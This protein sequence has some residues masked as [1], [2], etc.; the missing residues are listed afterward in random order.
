MDPRCDKTTVLTAS[1]TGPQVHD[2]EIN[3][4]GS[5][6]I[7]SP[8]G[9]DMDSDTS[10]PGPL[11]EPALK[12]GAAF[13]ATPITLPQVSLKEDSSLNTLD[14]KET[15]SSDMTLTQD[16][17]DTSGKLKQEIIKIPYVIYNLDAHNH[18]YIS[19]GTNIAYTDNEEPEMEYFKIA[20][21]FEEVQEAIQYRNH[22]PNHPKLPVPPQSDLISSPAKVKLHRRVELKDH[23]A[24]EE[25]KKCFEELCQQFP[26]V[27]STNNEDIGRTNLIT[28]DIDTGDS[29]P[30][31]KKLYTLPL[32]HYECIQ[33]EIE[34][35]ERAGIITRDVSPWA[36][37]V[38]IVPKKSALGKA[39]RRRMC[40]DFCA[41]NALQPTVIKAD[42]KAKGNFTLH[43]LPNIDHLYAQLKGAKIFTTLDLRS[44]YYHIE[45][46]QSS[47]TKTAFVTPFGK[48]EFNMVLFGLAQAPTYF[49]ALINKVLKGLHKFAM[50]YLDDIFIFSKSEEEH[51]EHLRIIFQSLK[52][53]GLKLK[54]SKCDFM[55]KHIQ[56]LGHFILKEGIQPLPEKL[57]SIKTMPAPRN[58]KEI[59]QF[60]G[61]AGY[62]RKFVPRFSDLSRPLTRLTCK[63]ALIKWTKEYEAVFQMLK[64]ALC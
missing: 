62:Y 19:K 63:D 49:Q 10:P 5:E 55:K 59:K 3:E 7:Q 25:T 21:T 46:G 45:L 12:E 32:K 13:E 50:A 34:S 6:S 28:M 15:M 33:Q 9:S 2:I 27:F 14:K 30:S 54:R 41:I 20:E 24:T 35:L 52:A 4:V 57:E 64:D 56:Y 8:N 36:S 38:V 51:L 53:T 42:S 39:L 43:P 17:S 1:T 48:Y 11:Q 47:H 40:I 58:A 60:L 16:K 22:L 29:L 61:L 26:E 18:V 31:T 37:P 44:G 23:D